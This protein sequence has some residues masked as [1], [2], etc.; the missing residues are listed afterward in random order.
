V[1]SA[2]KRCQNSLRVIFIFR[3]ADNLAVKNDNRIGRNYYFFIRNI[4]GNCPGLAE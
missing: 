2:R 4:F 3:L 1:F